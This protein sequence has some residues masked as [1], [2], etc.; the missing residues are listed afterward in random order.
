MGLYSRFLLPP[1]LD[2][3]MSSSL[4]AAERPRALAGVGGDVL[5]IGFGSG[6]NLEFYPAGVKRITAVDP[7]PGLKRIAQRRI[8]ESSIP[9]E[10]RMLGGERMPLDSNRFDSAVSTWTLCSIREVEKALSEVFRVLKPGGRF[11]FIEHGLSPDP[12]IS[13]WQRRL[14]PIQKALADGCHLN[15]DVD[16]LVESQG[17]EIIELDNYYLQRIPRIMG[18]L[19]RGVARKS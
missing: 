11:F 14:T 2:R 12:G 1:L 15:R 9:V 3:A 8:E 18:F 4:I 17:L 6:L 16:R 10:H 19:Y 7:N 13:R 5:E